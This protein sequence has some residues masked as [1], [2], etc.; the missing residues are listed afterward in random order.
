M[1]PPMPQPSRVTLIALPDQSGADFNCSGG[2]SARS[3]N[4]KTT[5]RAYVSYPSKIH[6]RKLAAS[7][8]K[9]V[10]VRSLYQV[11]DADRTAATEFIE[12]L[13]PSVQFRDAIFTPVSEPAPIHLSCRRPRLRRTRDS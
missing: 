13:L 12:F 5:I 4:G 8:R 7:M 9:C 11:C 1:S 2:N 3:A 6:P 10:G